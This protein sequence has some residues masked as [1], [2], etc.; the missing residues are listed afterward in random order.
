L[1]DTVSAQP[2]PASPAPHLFKSALIAG[3]VCGLVVGLPFL[4]ALNCFCCAPVIL[5]GMWAAYLLSREQ[6]RRGGRFDIGHGALVGLIAGLF[7]GLTT[8]VVRG[9]VL[10]TGIEPALGVLRNVLQNA[11]EMPPELREVLDKIFTP[12]FSAF[13]FL[14][15]LMTRIVVYAFFATAGGLLGALLFKPKAPTPTGTG[16]ATSD[17]GTTGGGPPPINA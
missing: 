14:I 17:P 15:G 5:C 9:V 6:A 4:G 2:L 16:G 13:I 8:S 1:E 10:A 12:G 7:C 3:L 11:H